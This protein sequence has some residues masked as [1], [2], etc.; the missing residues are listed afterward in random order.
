MSISFVV[1]VAIIAIIARL[2]A[3]PRDAVLGV[4]RM[5]VGNKEQGGKRRG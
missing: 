1:V 3:K 5:T 4:G 2:R